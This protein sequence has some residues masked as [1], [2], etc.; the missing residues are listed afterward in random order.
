MALTDLFNDIADAIREKDGTTAEIV[1]STFPDRIRAIPTGIGGVQLESITIIN[2]PNKTYYYAGDEFDPTGMAVRANY[3]NGQSLYVNLSNLTFT[4]SGPLTAETTSI[5]VNFQWGIKMVSASQPISVVTVMCFGVVWDYSDPSP[6]LTRLTPET[7]PNGYVTVSVNGDPSPAVGTG[8]GN[9]PFDGYT[10]WAGMQ[11]YNII[12]GAVGPKKGE[13]GFSRNNE[14]AVYIPKFWY[15]VVDDPANNKRY[16]YISN[17]PYK[18]MEVHPGS[19]KYL[20]RYKCGTGARS[21]A[22]LARDSGLNAATAKTNCLAKGPG[23]DLSTHKA[24]SAVKI[25][26]LVEFATWD[27]QAAIGGGVHGGSNTVYVS[28]GLTDEMIYH[29]GKVSNDE[30]PQIQYRWIEGPYGNSIEFCAG[31]VVQNLQ[32]SILENGIRSNPIYTLGSGI[33]FGHIVKKLAFIP[34]HKWLFFPSEASTD[35]LSDADRYL[36]DESYISNTET[37]ELIH[38]GDYY[39]RKNYGGMFVMY[40]TYANNSSIN[41]GYRY[42]YDPSSE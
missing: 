30:W 8:P 10:P 38:V 19:D 35:G 36:T 3:S 27:S 26:Y 18:E 28:A 23:F 33:S 24:W 6:A 13:A 25:L 21:M 31:L 15:N 17:V 11:E 39:S 14:T 22:G 37:E 20:A 12:G 9:S 4:P 32:V 5:T 1:A 41:Y 2:P 34:Q 42:I 40:A 16:W 7:D 29:T